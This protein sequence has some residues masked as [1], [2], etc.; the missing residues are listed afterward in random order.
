MLA[1]I[2]IGT[3]S[4]HN[5]VTRESMAQC[6]SLGWVGTG[7]DCFLVTVDILLKRV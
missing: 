4:A 5:D 3:E 2:S 1:K 7:A 6:F